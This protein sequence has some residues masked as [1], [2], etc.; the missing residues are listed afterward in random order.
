MLS[1]QKVEVKGF[2]V[3]SLCEMIHENR[4]DILGK[5]L[6][7]VVLSCQEVLLCKDLGDRYS[8]ERQRASFSPCRGTLH[9]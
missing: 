5:V 6:D 3:N 9:Q 4:S 1:Y 8:R 2:N 7:D